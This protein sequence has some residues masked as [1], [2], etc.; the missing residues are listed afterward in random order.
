MVL[1]DRGLTKVLG[2]REATM[3]LGGR[4]PSM[5]LRVLVRQLDGLLIVKLDLISVLLRKVEK[6]GLVGLGLNS[7]CSLSGTL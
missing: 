1:G 3:V 5:L 2:G 4:E 6:M 7:N